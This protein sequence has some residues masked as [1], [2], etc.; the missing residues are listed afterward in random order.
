MLLSSK[1]LALMPIL[2]KE[3]LKK[4]VV[5][6]STECIFDDAKERISVHFQK[7]NLYFGDEK[8]NIYNVPVW[9]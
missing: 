5:A 3:T 8:G 7:E 4:P 9:W 2:T 6:V 1:S